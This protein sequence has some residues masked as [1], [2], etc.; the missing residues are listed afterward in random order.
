MLTVAKEANWLYEKFGDGVDFEERMTEIRREL[1]SL[2]V[3]SN[4]LIEAI[5]Q[6]MKKMGL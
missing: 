1:L 3:K 2:Q 4:E 6:N 5:S